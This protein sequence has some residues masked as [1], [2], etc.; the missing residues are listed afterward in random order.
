VREKI[1]AIYDRFDEDALRRWTLREGSKDLLSALKTKGI[2]IG[3]VSNVGN[4]VLERALP[5]LDLH[6]FFNV[7]VSRNDVQYMK[8][9]GEG[10]RLALKRLQVMNDKA[11]YVGDSL[12]DIQAAKAAGVRVIIIMSKESSKAELL[13]PEPDQL[14]T[15]FNELLRPLTKVT[16]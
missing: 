13:S 7:V 9:S 10:L 5:K 1:G 15:H 3:L 11:L 12:D 8:P 16:S 4:K 14:I 6:P 2:K